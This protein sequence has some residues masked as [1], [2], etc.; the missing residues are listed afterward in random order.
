MNKCWTIKQTFLD[1]CAKPSLLVNKE[2]GGILPRQQAADDPAHGE[3]CRPIRRPSDFCWYRLGYQKRKT[4]ATKT[5]VCLP[6]LSPKVVCVT[7]LT[8]TFLSLMR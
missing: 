4:A 8:R 3:T 2:V 6:S 5:V 1:K 7:W